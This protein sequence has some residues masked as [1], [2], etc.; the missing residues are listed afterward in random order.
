[1]KLTD[2]NPYWVSHGGEGVTRTDGSPIPLRERIG[3]SCDCPCGSCGVPLFV[4]F[5]NPVDGLGPYST[6]HP[7]WRREGE[8][9]DT[10]STTPSILRR[11]GCGWHGYITNGEIITV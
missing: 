11:G 10:L 5:E 1:M 9:F 4:G 2:L 6:H 3:I 7:L 8:T